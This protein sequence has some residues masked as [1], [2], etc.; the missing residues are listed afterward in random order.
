M[1]F[2]KGHNKV[3]GR[4]KG[5]PNRVS[6]SFRDKVLMLLENQ[7]PQIEKDM[8][9]L[10]PEQRIEVWIKLMEFAIPK[11]QR[12]EATIENINTEE[13][14]EKRGSL[15]DGLDME[16]KRR[17]LRILSEAKHD[18]KYEGQVPKGGNL[19][20]IDLDLEDR[21]KVLAIILNSDI[22]LVNQKQL[23]PG[24]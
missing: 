14:A 18:P 24:D 11:L 20:I 22:Q 21:K 9:A 7:Y 10:S 1:K 6:T 2:E 13:A 15:F 8:K 4:L 5:T 12:S 17:I 19:S 16:A 3:G 23:P